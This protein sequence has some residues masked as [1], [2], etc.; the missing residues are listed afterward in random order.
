MKPL[1]LTLKTTP[2]HCVDLSPLTPDR[3]ADLGLGAIRGIKLDVGRKGALV[4]DLF[5]VRGRDTSCIE[6]H[7][8]CEK[9]V[10]IGAQMT[11]GTI[12]VTGPTGD[13]LGHGMQGGT[14]NVNGDTG[15]LGGNGMSGGLNG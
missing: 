9:L 4:D 3:L 1:T 5:K 11:S 15:T 12:N 7:R 14:I 10:N 6:I 13:Y 8:S 2:A